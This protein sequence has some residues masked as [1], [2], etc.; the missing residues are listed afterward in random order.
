MNRGLELDDAHP[1]Y[2][3]GEG[4]QWALASLDMSSRLKKFDAAIILILHLTLLTSAGSKAW[5]R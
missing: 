1:F 2:D 3:A 5:D 4:V